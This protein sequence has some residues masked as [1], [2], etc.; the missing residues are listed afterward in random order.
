MF[1]QRAS[2]RNKGKVMSDRLFLRAA[3]S[4]DDPHILELFKSSFGREFSEDWW[5]WFSHECPTGLTRTYVIE[6]RE[7]GKFA[8]SYSLLPIKLRLNKAEIKASLA[9]NANTHPDYQRRGLFVRIGQFVLAHERDF[10][11][12][13]T[14]GMPNPK[15]YPGHMKVGWD[16]LCK[17]PFLVK[18]NSIVRSHRCRQV[19]SF[20]K[21][22]DDFYVKIAERFSFILIKD[23]NFMNWRVVSRPDQKY[24]KFLYEEGSR[25]MGY[26]VLKHFDEKGYR[27]S[28]ILDIQA[29]TDEALNELIA[30]AES[31]SSDRDELNM[32]T[33]LRNPYHQAFLDHGFCQRESQD[34][35]IIHFNY[36]EKESIEQGNWWFCLAD[37]D[38]Y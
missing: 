15:A 6:D 38:V 26:I 18:R 28:H 1:G 8:A 16:V 9:T 30:A 27:K 23:H 25:I 4:D 19:E 31:F 13:V 2:P 36:G 24:T 3:T 21:R 34:L 7:A 5:R 29:D 20:D 17:L 11:T 32:W 37:N 22:F 33:N 35:V 14:L 12:R 10:D